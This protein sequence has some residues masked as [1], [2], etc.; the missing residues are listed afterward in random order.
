VESPAH[1][2]GA[3]PGPLPHARSEEPKDG[4]PAQELTIPIGSEEVL[5]LLAVVLRDGCANGGRRPDDVARDLLRAGLRTRLDELGL[6]WAPN[7]EQVDS[8]Q[9]SA[10]RDQSSD[11]EVGSPTRARLLKALRAALVVA[12]LVVV[13]GGYLG[14]WPWTG[15]RGN[16]QVWDWL[17]LLLLPLAFATLPLWL[18]YANRISRARRVGYGVAVAGFAIF[19]VAGYAVPLAWTGFAG[20]DLWDWLTLLLLPAM[21]ITVQTWSSTTR[22]VRLHHRVAIAALGAGWIVTVI[23][24]YAW[25]WT[26]TGYQGNTLW[27]WLQLLLLPLIFPTVLAPALLRFVAGDVEKAPQQVSTA[28]AAPAAAP[29]PRAPDP[30]AARSPGEKRTVATT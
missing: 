11:T 30:A 15:F 5:G 13:S 6:P 28:V 7:A 21:L 20:H 24:G 10:D 29:A 23:G 17:Q 19:V 3:A 14:G 22:T 8:A 16:E 18:R 26:W 9:G 25:A 27:D 1:D 4:R 12:A 2:G